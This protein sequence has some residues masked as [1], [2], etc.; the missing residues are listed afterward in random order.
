[1]SLLSKA[2][3]CGFAAAVGVALLSN[4]LCSDGLI[5]CTDEVNRDVAHRVAERH[6]EFKRLTPFPDDCTNFVVKLDFS[7]HDPITASKVYLESPRISNF[8]LISIHFMAL[9]AKHDLC[10]HSFQLF[11]L[12]L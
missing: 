10:A 7:S 12:G 8:N 5:T 2:E 9:L 11:I 6:R 1:M 4:R 3:G